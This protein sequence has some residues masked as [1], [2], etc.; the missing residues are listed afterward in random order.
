MDTYCPGFEGG[1][2][3]GAHHWLHVREGGLLRGHVLQ[4]R[5]LLLHQ[6]A[7]KEP[8]LRTQNILEQI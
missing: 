4:V 2:A 8:V 6:P 7:S 5:Q 3:G 1:S